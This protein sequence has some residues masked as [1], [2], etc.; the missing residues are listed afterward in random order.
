MV[1]KIKEIEK[2]SAAEALDIKPGDLLIS[3]DGQEIEDIFDYRMHI[4]SERYTML[5]RDEEGQD[6]ELDIEN[7]GLDPGLIFDTGLMS[8]YRSCTNNCIFCFIDQMPPGMRKTLYFKDDDSRLSFLQGNYITLT[9]MKQHDIDRIISLKLEPINISIHTTDPK[10]RVKMLHNRYA[11]ESLKFL[12]DLYDAQIPMNGQIVLCRDIN[13]GE[14]LKKTIVDLIK[15]L[16]YMQSV[17]VVPVGLTKYRNKLAALEPYDRKSAC[18]VLDILDEYRQLCYKEYGTHFIH[19][20]DEFYFLA[21]RDMPSEWEYDGYPQIENGV[22]MTR[23]F[24]DEAYAALENICGKRFD[25]KEKTISAV[26][27]FLFYNSLKTIC[28]K[29]QEIADVSINIFPI[30]NDF[31][32]HLI[33]VSG[34]ITGGDMIAQLRQ[35]DRELLGDKLL[36]PSNM[37]RS[38]EEVFLDDLTVSDV[39]EQLGIDVQIVGSG[40]EAF[41]N[42]TLGLAQRDVKYRQYEL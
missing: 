25:T 29:I 19:A 17:S 41:V 33:T 21:G 7:D 15:L 16:P 1:H 27:G 9:N 42:A 10:L 32:G 22:G 35:V 5:I 14:H 31:F 28:E 12:Q 8:E 6:W 37:L 23:S 4:E 20:S 18:E 2:G 40:G 30:R 3:I 39:R 34:L 24:M 13:D 11:G 38:G 26:T 36:I